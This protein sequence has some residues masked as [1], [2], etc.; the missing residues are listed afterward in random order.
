MDQSQ[1]GWETRT[2][3]HNIRL[4]TF[5]TPSKA[6]KSVSAR[7]SWLSFSRDLL[8]Q[9][10]FANRNRRVWVTLRSYYDPNDDLLQRMRWRSCVDNNNE[11][12][13]RTSHTLVRAQPARHADAISTLPISTL[14][15]HT[16]P[17]PVRHC[18]CTQIASS[19]S[20]FPHRQHGQH[21]S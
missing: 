8:L 10:L 5:T 18:L 6:S 11:P 15:S 12:T 1:V 16:R 20:K 2:D 21:H 19:N 13:S 9:L 7:T 17:L 14:K 4:Y 3:F